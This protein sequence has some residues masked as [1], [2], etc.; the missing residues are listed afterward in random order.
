MQDEHRISLSLHESKAKPR[1][2][3]VNNKELCI[4]I[5][6]VRFTYIDEFL[7]SEV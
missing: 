3:S 1:R 5:C 6:D 2:M 7:L 4:L